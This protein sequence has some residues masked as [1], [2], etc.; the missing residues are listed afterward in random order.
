MSSVPP[1]ASPKKQRTEYDPKEC[2]YPPYGRQVNGKMIASLV[3]AFLRP[4]SEIPYE[5]VGS[6]DK[7]Q[8]S[9]CRR[10]SEK[11]VVRTIA[12]ASR[13]AHAEDRYNR[14]N[15]GDQATKSCP[16][17]ALVS[18][19]TPLRHQKPKKDVRRKNEPYHESYPI[20]GTPCH[21]VHPLSRH[22]FILKNYLSFADTLTEE[23]CPRRFQTIKK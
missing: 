11:K 17:Q 12:S 5:T 2:P 19:G 8:H 9:P 16:A 15:A 14:D 4:P 18:P 13:N 22:H 23:P 20:Q 3:V 21:S 1:T 10:D 7:R 6:D